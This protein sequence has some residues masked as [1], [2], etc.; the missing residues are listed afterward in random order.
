MVVRLEVCRNRSGWEVIHDP[1]PGR[2]LEIE[3]TQ[4]FREYGLD[5][6]GLPR[7]RSQGSSRRAVFG[8]N[9]SSP[10]TSWP[11]G[12]DGLG[13]KA[14]H[15]WQH[16]YAITRRI[17]PDPWRNRL[18]QVWDGGDP[19]EI[20]KSLEQLAATAATDDL[21]AEWI[22]LLAQ[23]LWDA[24]RFE[25]A[26]YLL[27][28]TAS[29]W[30]KQSKATISLNFSEIGTCAFAQV[31]S[32]GCGRAGRMNGCIGPADSAGDDSMTPLRQAFRL[33]TCVCVTIRRRPLTPTFVVLPAS[34]AFGP[35]D[36][37][38]SS[39]SVT[40]S[41]ICSTQRVCWSTFNQ[42]VCALRFFFATTCGQ[43]GLVQQIPF[44][45]RPRILPCVLSRDEILSLFEAATACAV[46]LL[47]TAYAA[48]LRVSEVVHLQVQDIDMHRMVLHVRHAKGLKD[49]FVPLSPVLLASSAI[50]GG[51]SARRSGCFPAQEATAPS[52]AGVQLMRLPQAVLWR[53]PE[54][55]GDHA[56]AAAQLRHA[57]ARSRRRRA[58]AAAVAGTQPPGDHRAL[59]CTFRAARRTPSRWTCWSLPRGPVRAAEPPAARMDRHGR[60]SRWKWRRDSAAMARPSERV[61]QHSAAKQKKPLRDLAA[62]RTAALGGHVDSCHHCG[63]RHIATTRAAIAIVRSARR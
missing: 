18:R 60:C 25:L 38:G 13:R 17:V 8:W 55:A 54:Q 56:H 29:R 11:R 16:L 20:P 4:I 62:C 31:V 47:H 39:M 59:L 30:S 6:H 51:T 15:G 23:A 50:T 61:R 41:C 44:G 43:P 22:V 1:E 36:P 9:W 24:R 49:R 58:D 7:P 34:L 3:Y 42:T 27:N 57:P 33:T 53:R 19:T 21:L 5:V 37:L 35:P 40:S 10:W 63:Q 48:G 12:G 26:I 32:H 46:T 14:S 2:A 52:I 28:E 45:K